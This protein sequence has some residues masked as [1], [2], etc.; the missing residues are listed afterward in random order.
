VAVAALAITGCTANS[1][2]AASP[3][4][5]AESSNSVTPAPTITESP[6][7]DSTPTVVTEEETEEPAPLADLKIVKSGFSTFK[8]KYDDAKQLGYGVIVENPDP[9]QA[10]WDVDLS[11]AFLDESGDVID[12][13]E[14]TFAVVLPGQQVAWADTLSDYS[15]DWSGVKKMEVLL[16]EPTWEPVDAPGEY[17]FAKLKMTRDMLRNIKVTGRL[18]STFEK[19]MENPQIVTVFYRGSKIVG[20]GW[21]FLENARNNAPIE[22]GTS[23]SG[24]ASKAEVYGILSNLSLYTP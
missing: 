7:P 21:T 12:T 19:D 5:A 15:G 9:K 17:S 18:K 2:G 24:K 23:Y 11:I 6:T 8:G 1:L 20:G 13:V 4:P 22:I 3:K 14:E 10:A 16:G